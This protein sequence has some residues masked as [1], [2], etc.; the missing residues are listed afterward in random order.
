MSC[1]LAITALH[2]HVL[3]LGSNQDVDY[4]AI[5]RRHLQEAIQHLPQARSSDRTHSSRFVLDG[6]PYEVACHVLSVYFMALPQDPSQKTLTTPYSTWLKTSREYFAATAGHWR[7]KIQT[8][9]DPWSGISHGIIPCHLAVAVPPALEELCRLGSEL[10]EEAIYRDAVDRLVE[11]IALSAH[12]S[13]QAASL[14]YWP[15]VVSDAFL[16]L[17]YEARPRA[18]VILAYFLALV[19]RQRGLW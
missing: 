14:V 9:E 6:Q 7:L 12:P 19:G 15:A 2:L 16:Q 5:S 13:F 18:L 10:P 1:I 3:G 11:T 17:I 8:L 4:W